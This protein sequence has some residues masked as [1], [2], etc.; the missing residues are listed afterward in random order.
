[1]VFLRLTRYGEIG[2][3]RRAR[4]RIA[5][6]AAA[7]ADDY[8]GLDDCFAFLRIR[9]SVERQFDLAFSGESAPLE[10]D[11]ARAEFTAAR[12]PVDARTMLDVGC[13]TGIVTSAVA[14][15]AAAG[16]PRDVC[17]LEL[18]SVGVERVRALGL[19]CEKGSIDRMPFADGAFD[20]VMANEVLEH[21]NDEL[22]AAARRELARVAARY[23]LITV[24][25]RDHLPT[26]RQTCPHCAT[27]S[28]PW[29]HVRSFHSRDMAALFAGFRAVE[30][31]EFGPPVPDGDRLLTQIWR[32]PRRLHHPL[33]GGVRCP[34]CGHT[35][36]QPPATRPRASDF[37]LHP[38]AS[39]WYAIDFL[40]ARSSPTCPRWIFALYQRAV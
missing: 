35:N 7:S 8:I 11:L 19:K 32:L 4:G 20:L 24:P 15:S 26:L 16:G 30:V 39:G 22:F 10:A 34:L 31:C 21:L 40:A 9:M 37:L 3:G 14:K 17:G 29:G 12:V 1:M 6:H 13:G 27:D 5:A 25:N 2:R 36:P 28:V 38:L 18:S 33:K 23:L